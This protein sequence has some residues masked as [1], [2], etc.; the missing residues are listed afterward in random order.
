MIRFVNKDGLTVLVLRDSDTAPVTPSV[1]KDELDKEEEEKKKK[2][3]IQ[4][5]GVSKTT[6]LMC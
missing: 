2:A 4:L 3:S 5:Q 1:I 6:W